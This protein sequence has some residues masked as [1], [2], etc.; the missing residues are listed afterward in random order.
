MGVSAQAMKAVSRPA[1]NL[2]TQRQE[3]MASASEH[4]RDST[5]ALLIENIRRNVMAWTRW[6]A[7]E[8]TMKVD[9]TPGG[10]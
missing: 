8:P 2:R 4:S 6:A 9:Q 5:R 7:F 3:P 1:E 10:H